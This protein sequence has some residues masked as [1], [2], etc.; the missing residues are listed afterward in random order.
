MNRRLSFQVL[1]SSAALFT[2]GSPV[3][4]QGGDECAQATMVSMGQTI[5]DTAAATNSTPAY[6]CEANTGTDLWFEFVAPTTD[7]YRFDLCGT[8]Y[9]TVLE[10]H[11]GTCTGGVVLG[12]SDDA[13]DLASWTLVPCTASTSY[14][15]RVGGFAGV[16]GPGILDISDGALR[17]LELAAHYPFNETVPGPVFDASGNGQDGFAVGITIDQ[18][19][20]RP[21]TG[22]CADFDGV[23]S[24]VD[25]F[26][27]GALDALQ[28]D[29]S[30]SVWINLNASPLGFGV[31]RIFGNQGPSGSWSFG[32]RGTAGLVFTTHGV[33]DYQFSAT[34][35]P[36]T[37]YHVAVVMNETND[38]T[39]YLDGQSL[40]TVGGIEQA[41]SPRVEY[42]I[43]AWSPI[44]S[45]PERVDALIDDVQIYGG[46]LSSAQVL[47]L[48][49]NPGTTFGDNEIGTSYCM[50]V[51]NSSGVVGTMTAFGSLSAG[52]NDVTLVGMSLP[53]NNFGIFVVSR[54]QGFIVMP[55]LSIGN[56]CLGGVVG[57]YNQVG[58]ILSTGN[59][60]SYELRINLTTIPQG[61]NFVTVVSGD[62]WNFQT[63]HRDLQNGIPV[64]NF[65]TG[66]E[67]NFL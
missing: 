6:I 25:I 17:E 1:G 53:N 29:F 58:Q 62:T 47:S 35:T 37:W 49:Q 57:R 34:L 28:N 36:G 9:D 14:F 46:Q 20:A 8:S 50:G 22:R 67:L 27:A 42:H 33:L 41:K 40:G 66:L 48:F 61:N 44:F 12:C 13:C 54:D 55:G 32:V 30:A 65:S 56:L 60:G 23:T 59:T 5:Y 2:L 15:V 11:E 63:W 3:F 31:G 38:V 24:S 10:V 45:L 18:P 39:M 19:G 51:P 21:G 16:A 43:G 4:A 52:V 26:G 7:V 64:S